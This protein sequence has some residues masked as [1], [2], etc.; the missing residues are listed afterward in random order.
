MVRRWSSR[1]LLGTG[2]LLVLLQFVPY[3]R[4]HTNPPVRQEPAWNAPRTR[5]L[6]VRACYACH[7]NQTEWP[8]YSNVAP[9]SWLVQRD[10]DLGR[11]KLNFSEFDRRQEEADE[12]AEEVEKGSMPPPIFLPLHP[13]AVLSAAERAELAA[14][15]GATLGRGGGDR[16]SQRQGRGDAAPVTPEL[17]DATGVLGH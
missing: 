17:A 9:A 14:G 4:Q 2:L 15:L 1:V 10:V 12:A 3:G 7:S 8:W 16:N 5:E 13:E 11:R 6:S